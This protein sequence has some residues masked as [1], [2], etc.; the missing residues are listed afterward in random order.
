MQLPMN[1]FSQKGA[2]E[3]LSNLKPSRWLLATLVSARSWSDVKGTK[4]FWKVERKHA[5]YIKL[6]RFK[7]SNVEDIMLS[8][9]LQ[10]LS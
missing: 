10:F 1:V 6:T 4:G 2:E 3:V 7:N 9:G 8:T 5:A